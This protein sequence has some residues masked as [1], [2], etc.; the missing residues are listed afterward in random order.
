MATLFR[1]RA[2]N[3]QRRPAVVARLADTILTE[4]Q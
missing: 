4:N 1:R 3:E 2:G